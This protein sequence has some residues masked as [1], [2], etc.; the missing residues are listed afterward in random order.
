ME[1]RWSQEAS[2]KEGAATCWKSKKRGRK[3]G[4][5]GAWDKEKK[6]IWKRLV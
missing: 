3:K 5:E 2:L 6:H 4:K 1:V